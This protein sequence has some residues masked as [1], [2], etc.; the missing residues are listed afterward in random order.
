[1][2]RVLV[3]QQ[4]PSRNMVK[5]DWRLLGWFQTFDRRHFLLALKDSAHRTEHWAHESE[6]ITTYASFWTA[7]MLS[8]KS[9]DKT[10]QFVHLSRLVEPR[11]RPRNWKCDVMGSIFLAVPPAGSGWRLTQKPREKST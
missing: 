1:M 5:C 6:Q 4:R 7:N 8:V 2:Q 9:P 10:L 3:T 11:G